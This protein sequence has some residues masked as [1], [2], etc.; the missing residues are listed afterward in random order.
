MLNDLP[1]ELL[2]NIINN[3]NTTESILNVRL[4]N[5][6]S[7]NLLKEVP[8]YKYGQ[9]IYKIVFNENIIFKYRDDEL[10]K[11]IEFIPYGGV[12]IYDYVNYT[13]IYFFSTPK[14]RNYNKKALINPKKIGC[15]IF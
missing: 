7:Y 6:K 9:L 3:I 14:Q 15:N 1:S 12:K 8:I 13:N 4:L 5:K 11:K 2:D 10:I